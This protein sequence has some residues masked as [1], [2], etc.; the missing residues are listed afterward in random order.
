MNSSVAVLAKAPRAGNAKTRLAPPCTLVQAAELAQV[1]LDQTLAVVRGSQ[2]KHRY[3]LYDEELEID[4]M[5]VIPQRGNSLDE[6]LAFAFQDV[7]EAVIIIGMDTP[8]IQVELLDDAL[9]T[10][11]AQDAVLGP[12]EDGGYWAL[13]LRRSEMTVCLGVPMSRSD[14]AYHQQQRLKNLG[15]RYALLPQLRDVDTFADA[16]AVAGQVPDSP[17]ARAVELVR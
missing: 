10:L 15:L 8:Q 1:C 11:E 17:F 4:G 6:K 13:G 2:A 7:G 9:G 16:I 3:L 12:T 5:T 14:T